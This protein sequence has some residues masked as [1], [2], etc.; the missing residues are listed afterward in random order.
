M[1]V[2]L[3]CVYGAIKGVRDI[4]K[5]KAMEKST[6]IEVLFFYTLISFILVTPSFKTAV[7][8]DYGYMWLIFIKSAVIF[9]AW[10]CGFNAIKRLPVGLYGI[11][12]MSRVLISTTLGVVV[13]GEILTANK[14]IGMALVIAGLI[15]VNLSGRKGNSERTKT[16][17]IVLVLISCF[18]NATSA[19]F[20]KILMQHMTSGQLQFWYMLFLVLLYLGYILVT[21][22]KI[23]IKNAL[24]NYW[25]IILSVLFVIGDRALFIANSNADSTLVTM[26][27]IKQCSV[28]VTIIGGRIVFKE[29][30]TLYKL[31]CA[32]VIIVGIVIA[33]I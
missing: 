6:A 30:R 22:T 31:A 20:D 1:W 25:I 12:D 29:E 17:Y 24:K 16:V 32:A 5:K 19:M 8:I 26:T 33:V 2:A 14:V 4:I 7:S 13:L 18:G 9:V 11:M 27:L 3:V 15:L 23:S 28:L 21:R 10:I